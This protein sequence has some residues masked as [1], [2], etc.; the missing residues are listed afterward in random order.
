M[1][2]ICIEFGPTGPADWN[3]KP[4]AL[5]G[6]GPSLSGFDLDQLRRRYRVV[7]VNA[8]IFDLP[9]AEA[10]FSLDRRAMRHWWPKLRAATMP[11]YFAIPDH[12]LVNFYMPPTPNMRFIRRHPGAYFS[13]YDWMITCGGTSGYGAL[14]LAFK[15][16]A[17]EITLFGFDYGASPSGAWHHNEGHYNFFQGQQAHKWREFAASFDVAAPVLKAAG[18]KVLNASPHSA[19]TAFPRT[20]PEKAI[21]DPSLRRL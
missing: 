18:V 12:Y 8:S 10:G 13:A 7:A 20:S 17:R 21:D 14:Q 16:G 6:G 9:W 5:V 4:V 1:S 2:R 11:L 15:K 3:D 19:I